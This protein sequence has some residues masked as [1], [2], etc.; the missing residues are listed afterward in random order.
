MSRAFTS[1]PLLIKLKFNFRGFDVEV[2]FGSKLLLSFDGL[3]LGVNGKSG[4]SKNERFSDCR[5]SPKSEK[6]EYN[7]NYLFYRENYF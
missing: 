3:E 6:S 2:L 4:A 5:D 1:L 7:G